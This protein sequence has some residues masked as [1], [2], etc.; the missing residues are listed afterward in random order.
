MLTPRSHR[1]AALAC[2]ALVSCGTALPALDAEGLRQAS[3]D[4][5][6]ATRGCTAQRKATEPDLFGWDSGSRGKVK[7]TAEQ[8]LVVV[9]FEQHGCDVAIAV[10]NC[11]ST[12]VGYRYTPRH[13]LQS[14]FAENDA[15]LY[16]HFP[17]AVAGLRARLGAGRGV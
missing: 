8:G 13:A 4:Q 15:D 5:L 12:K 7:A 14:R 2:S 9:H 3:L 16:V 1:L 10:L 11:T 17:I 6:G